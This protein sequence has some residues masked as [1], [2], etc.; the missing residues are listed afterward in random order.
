MTRILLITSIIIFSIST[1][2]SQMYSF[3]KM[4]TDKDGKVYNENIA[5]D[6]F[7]YSK[8]NS[9]NFQ[10]RDLSILWFNV[11][12]DISA[13]EEVD[14]WD[15]RMDVS[16]NGDI[17][18]VYSDNHSGTGLQKIMFR[19][20]GIGEEWTEPIYI[21]QGGDVGGRNNHFPAVAY[22]PN[23]DIHAIYNVWAYENVRNYIGYSFYDAS[24]DLW[25]NGIEISEAG[26]SV[27]HFDSHH[28]LYSTDDNLPVVVWGYDNRANADYEEVYMKY[29]DGTSWSS[30][31]LVSTPDDDASAHYPYITSIGNNKAMIIFGEA[32]DVSDEREIRYRIY[33]E[34]THNLSEIQAI[35]QT[36]YYSDSYY[37]NYDLA[38]K[39]DG[40][41][42]IAIWENARSTP[43]AD[44]IKCVNYNVASEEFEMSE[45]KYINVT[46]GSF[47]KH[48]S[49]DC[50]ADG[51]TG[52]VYT[53]TYLETCNF[54]SFD[55]VDGFSE[56]KIFNEDDVAGGD[57]P[58]CGFDNEGNMHTVWADLRF[59]IPG[60]YMER[61]VFYEMGT[62]V[63]N[64]FAV[65]FVVT[66]ID[67]VTPIEDAEVIFNA[68]TIN[69]NQDGEVVFEYVLADNYSWSIS[70]TDYETEEGSID[71]TQNETVEVSLD[72]MEGVK[73]LA[74][75]GMK[76]YPNPTSGIINIKIPEKV[77]CSA[78]TISDLSGKIILK[79]AV[80]QNNIVI[81]LK[82]APGLYFV[83]FDLNDKIM[84]SRFIVE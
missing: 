29:F 61:E 84:Y 26:G 49:I 75:I 77:S 63:A 81:E 40:N 71:I 19:K 16:S 5:S 35:P 28:D 10:M 50:D 38:N 60:G 14:S 42:I 30:D 24:E 7:E 55:P 13:H 8:D 31:I 76:I 80:K 67:G 46:T 41:T 18:V 33:D 27:N 74:D 64:T 57:Y 43:Y 9:S 56:I 44:T 11:D 59:D 78:I 4:R 48:I 25:N 66:E 68:E 72:Q 23:G 52:I 39:N 79:K 22:S 73:T 21:D 62:N 65:T 53:D 20:K 12:F 69:T 1:A 17:C 15:P 32:T 83:R 2:F 3:E 51:N 6:N 82:T 54:I 70:K 47:P 37:Y 45:H 58:E 36:T 34:E